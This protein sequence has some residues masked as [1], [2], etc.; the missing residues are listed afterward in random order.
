MA[1]TVSAG[2]AA[3][4]P[5]GAGACPAGST[6]GAEEP[7]IITTIFKSTQNK[8]I[9]R[10]SL[11]CPTPNSPALII[12]HVYNIPLEFPEILSQIINAIIHRVN[13]RFPK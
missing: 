5:F 11:E 8:N 7:A 4:S 9:K 12:G 2:A 6:R 1:I 13:L 3:G 10:Q